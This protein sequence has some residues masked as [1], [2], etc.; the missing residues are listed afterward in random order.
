MTRFS[1]PLSVFVYQD[2]LCAWCYLAEARLA[3]LREEFKPLLR[4]KTRPYPLRVNEAQPT[5]EELST[6]AKEIR[7]A[8]REPE[9]AR[10]KADLWTGGDPPRS[11]VPALMALEAA[12]LQGPTARALLGKALQRAGLE[13]GINV[14]RTDVVFELAS[15]V[16]LQMNRFSAAFTSPET[17][18][19]ILE[20]HRIA[21]DRGIRGVPTLVV[22]GRWMISGLRETAEYREHL[23]QCLEKAGLA[24]GGHPEPTV[25]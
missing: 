18:R 2:V 21:D 25:H 13:Q 17:K 10:L 12:R 15:R 7:L 4:W 20:E 14:C 19:L 11:S 23:R 8:R 6:W 9:G 3:P 16:G 5:G 22:G 1:R 24:G